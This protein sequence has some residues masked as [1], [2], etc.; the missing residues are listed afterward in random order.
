MDDLPL[1][2]V[3]KENLDAVKVI[4]PERRKRTKEQIVDRTVPHVA[5]E[6]LEVIK[7]VSTERISERFEEQVVDRTVP[8]VAAKILE[9]TKDTPQER[10]MEQIDALPVPQVAKDNSRGG[11]DHSPGAHHGWSRLTTCPC[12]RSL[13]NS[14]R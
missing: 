4:L 11:Q 10:T 3:L 1:P 7:A 9:V 8:H 6:T 13:K 14:L 5:A 12:C 2:L